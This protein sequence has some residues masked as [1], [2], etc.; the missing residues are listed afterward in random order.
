MSE[1]PKRLTPTK[2]TLIRL[3]AKSGNQCA[4]EGCPH[5]LFNSDGV[6]IAEV[7]HI[8][9]ALTGGERFN[10]ELNN[11][12]RRAENN[13]ILFCKEH[14]KVT[15]NEIEYSVKRLREIK[16]KHENKFLGTRIFEL[17]NNN[18]NSF[19]QVY[20]Q[21]S[22]IYNLLT[23]LKYFKPLT[24]HIN[25][26]QGKLEPSKNFFRNN[27]FFYSENE[28]QL[29]NTI[30]SKFKNNEEQ[31][32]LITGHPSSGKTC[33]TV[34]L[35]KQLQQQ[36]LKP[37][38]V[39]LYSNIDET[40]LK[41]D[42]TIIKEIKDQKSIIILD[43]IHKNLSLA[44]ELYSFIE[45]FKDV[46]GIFISR[47]LSK[48]L[49]EIG[50]TAFPLFEI[51]KVKV[52]LSIDNVQNKFK[53]I[54]NT[55]KKIFQITDSIGNLSKVI[56]FCNANILKLQLLLEVWRDEAMGHSLSDVTA[57]HFNSLLRKKY[58]S[59]SI[60][61]DENYLMECASV[62]SFGIDFHYLGDLAT[63][64]EI[65]GSGLI[66]ETEEGLQLY[67][68]W[69]AKFAELILM[70]ILENKPAIDKSRLTSS[71]DELKK[72]NLFTYL[73][74]FINP[75]IS[76]F[77][78]PKNM[79]EII[80]LLSQ[81]KQRRLIV[82]ILN[83]GKYFSL[84]CNFIEHENLQPHSIK[85]L[86][87]HLRFNSPKHLEIIIIKY[88]TSKIF[89]DG[90]ISINQGYEILSYILIAAYKSN[91]S[92]TAANLTSIITKDHWKKLAISTRLNDLTLSTR[93]LK[94]Y[95]PPLAAD[96]LNSLSVE[97]WK[98]KVSSLPI[99]ILS[100]SLTE[101]KSVDPIL[102]NKILTSLDE[103][104]LRVEAH[105]L[106]FFRFEKVL[107]ELKEI[108][109]PMA[110]RI[111][112]S[113]DDKSFSNALTKAT[114][115][116]IGKGL[117]ILKIL[118]P[119]K[120]VNA[121]ENINDE[122]ILEK[123][124]QEEVR[125]VFRIISELD[126]VEKQKTI[127]IV[128]L[129]LVNGT[130]KRIDNISDYFNVIHNLEVIKYPDRQTIYDG[131]DKG[132]IKR[133]LKGESFQNLASGL[134]ALK[135]ANPSFAIEILSEALKLFDIKAQPLTALGPIFLKLRNIHFDTAKGLFN[136]IP[137]NVFVK[138]ALANDINFSQ[139]IKALD[140]LRNL[141]KPYTSEIFEAISKE[142]IFK[143][144][145]HRINIDLMLHSLDAIY[146]ISPKA[147]AEVFNSYKENHKNTLIDQQFD[148]LK[149]CSGLNKFNKFASK[150]ALQI[151][152]LFK[153]KLKI[154]LSGL[155]FKEL[156]TGLSDLANVSPQNAKEIL[157]SISFD[158]LHK[159]ALIIEKHHR[160]IAMGELKKVDNEWYEK[161]SKI[162]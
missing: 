108:D 27:L 162:L 106:K 60:L 4:F 12:Q 78:Y 113:L 111:Y 15:D 161:L 34:F 82:D 18:F 39:S 51:I 84:L 105:K 144:K 16:Q 117:V 1:K 66:I 130:L 48:E 24:E 120:T 121:Y 14:H 68:F 103:N 86:V 156:T 137:I 97:E 150:V 31:F 37:Y 115:A 160:A 72:Q 36:G 74:R 100:N 42:I 77:L 22:E 5:N 149:L 29:L 79:N 80:A 155:Q 69:H 116:Q 57:H 28:V 110:S 95:F 129:L 139:I 65:E 3:F 128:K 140:E 147:S 102:A 25:S 43:D 33:F 148:F 81:Q 118:N 98:N 54:I 107:S 94:N 126:K 124:G 151:T 21:Q 7:C 143:N 135:E 20:E 142:T 83:N 53:G 64:K 132:E 89:I 52:S 23:Q 44:V 73:N 159:K 70:C 75:E 55:Y 46:K 58:T 125:N 119:D 104:K 35:A 136:D 6:F 122:I 17:T 19:Q 158:D 146:K 127:G 141:D 153:P 157:R 93:L 61:I 92:K 67:E 101:I 2:E 13:L 90:L 62:Y 85:E 152:D 40:A 49:Q 56:N 32:A 123:L 87:K 8:E 9:A 30:Y 47:D 88:I 71:L 11:E 138:K 109:S 91:L 133:L 76:S 50:E 96:I 134:A 114:A 38:Y 10:P 63:K 112:S 145:A 45:Q 131:I 26:R 154:L 99:F 59:F 41:T